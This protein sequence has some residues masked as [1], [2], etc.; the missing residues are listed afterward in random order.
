MPFDTVVVLGV[1]IAAFAIFAVTL[2]WAN[3]IAK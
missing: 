1:V 3:S 2:A